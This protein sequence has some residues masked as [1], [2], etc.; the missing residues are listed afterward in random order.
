[1]NRLQGKLILVT[2]PVRSG[3]SEWAENLA[4]QSGQ[5]VVYLATSF[6]NPHDGEWQHRLKLHQLRR[7]VDWI[8]WEVP[9]ELA[10]AIAS[11]DPQVCL[12]IDSL[13]SWLANVLEADDLSWQEMQTHLLETLQITQ[14]QVI[15]V[16]EETGWGLVPAY[17]SGRLF[18]DRLG[19]LTRQVGAIATEVYLVTAGY[20]LNLKA[21]GTPLPPLNPS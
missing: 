18:R 20:A 2:G 19:S 17:P 12:L 7:P 14:A 16:A 9:V 1:M 11:T 5:T 8:T 15:I 4:L 6:A 3:K 10:E 13:G 21:L